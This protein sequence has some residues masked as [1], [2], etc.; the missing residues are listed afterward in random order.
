MVSG[1]EYGGDRLP[2]VG[3][4]HRVGAMTSGPHG[5]KDRRGGDEDGN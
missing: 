4:G 5:G 3:N 2:D 1:G